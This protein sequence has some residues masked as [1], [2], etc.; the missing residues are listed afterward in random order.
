MTPPI[1]ELLDR[2]RSLL[3]SRTYDEAVTEL[4]HAL[5]CADLAIRSGA[6]DALVVAALLHDVGHLLQGDER[7][8]GSPTDDLH[9]EAAGG[10]YLRRWF[11]PAV[12]APVILHVSAKRYLCAVDSSYLGRLSAG[13]AHSLRLQGGPMDD[14]E[15]TAF[16]QRAGW[17]D[18]V[19]L[20]R[21]DDAAKVVGAHAPSFE[22][23]VPLLRSLAGC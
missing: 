19:R 5:Q 9:H 10:R 17:E 3:A 13:S 15:R 1:D 20:R 18:A 21:W 12:T 7:P 16:E 22:H 11:G 4:D 6:D 23:H 2:Y 14:D 8:D